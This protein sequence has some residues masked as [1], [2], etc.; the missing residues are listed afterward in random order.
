MSAQETGRRVC[1]EC[2]MAWLLYGDGAE[3]LLHHG[4]VYWQ[5]GAPGSSGGSGTNR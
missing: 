3:C 4:R 2:V 5:D 1:I